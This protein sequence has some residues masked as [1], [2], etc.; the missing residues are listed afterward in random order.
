LMWDGLA[1]RHL[2]DLTFYRPPDRRPNIFSAD[3]IFCFLS[4][5]PDWAK[6][7]HLDCFRLLFT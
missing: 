7:R 5:W 2:V 1:P 3:F 4:V 6:F